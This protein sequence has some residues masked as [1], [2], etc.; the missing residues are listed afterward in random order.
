M[1]EGRRGLGEV[2]GG[3][4][5]AD[6]PLFTMYGGEGESVLH[7]AYLSRP[8]TH[9]KHCLQGLRA[10]QGLEVTEPTARNAVCTVPGNYHKSVKKII[11]Q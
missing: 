7:T 9:C 2:V 8:H 3:E 5:G 4:G 1:E 10:V 11:R 6:L